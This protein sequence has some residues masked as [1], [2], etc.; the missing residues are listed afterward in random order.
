MMM[1]NRW[2]FSSYPS[3][4]EQTIPHFRPSPILFF[5]PRDP[6]IELSGGW[7]FFAVQKRFFGYLYLG[8]S[9][10]ISE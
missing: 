8:T 4:L 7:R 10:V 1:L 5:P 2:A 9:P 3:P 6:L